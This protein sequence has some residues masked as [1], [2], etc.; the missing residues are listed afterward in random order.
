MKIWSWNVNGIRSCT[1]RGFL[2]WLAG[3]E[4]TVVALQEVRASWS[5]LTAQQRSPG[6]LWSHVVSAAK[7]GYS[8]VGLYATTPPDELT[9]SLG[10][11]AFDR[12]GRVQIARWGQ[13]VVAN[14]YFPNGNGKERDNSRIPYKL[15]FY[16]AM[17][18]RLEVERAAGR[19]VLV[20]GDFNTAHTAIDLARPKTNTKTSGFTEPE[21]AELTRWL[22]SGYV[23]TFR[24]FHPDEEGHYSWWSQRH[25]ARQNNVGW[26]IDL[27]LASEAAMP[28]VQSAT[29]AREVEGSDHCPVGVTLDPAIVGAQADE[30]SAAEDAAQL[31][32]VD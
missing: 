10:E 9:T 18:D 15:A 20:V 6:G 17:F 8:G 19:R 5:Q 2:R 26:R 31:E 25:G 4:G 23:D 28:F 21:R 7:P 14:A 13:L 12:E 30:A 16:R 3:C 1:K 32:E 29:I 22:E 24:H 11:H 27:V